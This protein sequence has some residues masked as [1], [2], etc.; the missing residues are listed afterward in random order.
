MVYAFGVSGVLL[1]ETWIIV[2]IMIFLGLILMYLEIRKVRY[3]LLIKA[4]ELHRFERDVKVLE[5]EEKIL[6][7]Y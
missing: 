7:K 6:G 2:M 1:F 4:R 3:L 5:Q